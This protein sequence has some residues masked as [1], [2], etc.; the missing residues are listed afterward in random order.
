MEKKPALKRNIIMFIMVVAIIIS[1]IVIIYSNINSPGPDKGASVPAPSSDKEATVPTPS[2]QTPLLQ[3]QNGTQEPPDTDEPQPEPGEKVYI[4]VYTTYRELGRV[5]E[6]YALENWDFDFEVQTWD[7]AIR[8]GY[9][10]IIN[11]VDD[12]LKNNAEPMEVFCV[13]A[14]YAPKYIRGEYSQYVCPYEE[15]GIDVDALLEKMDIPRYIIDAGTNKEGKIVALPVL[16]NA[17]VFMYRRSVAREVFGTDDPDKISEIIGGGTQSWD[18]FLEASK[19]LKKHGY[20]IVSGPGDLFYQ[21][22]DKCSISDLFSEDFRIKPEWEKLMDIAKLLYDNGYIKNTELWSEQW[23]KDNVGKGDK[24]FGT[25][26]ITEFRWDDQGLKNVYGDVFGDW[27]ICLP[28]FQ[29]RSDSYSGIM[30]SRNAANKE[31][32]K[33]II[34]WLTL[35][36]SESGFQY[37]LANG[38]IFDGQKFPV[39]SRSVLKETENTVGFLGN[40]DVNPIVLNALNRLDERY[41]PD[42]SPEDEG[43]LSIYWEFMT[44]T[45]AYIRGEKDKETAISDFTE[46]IRRRW[47][48]TGLMW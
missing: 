47:K 17:N 45:N 22:D 23:Y 7:D 3:E 15:L 14:P 18:K 19:T 34:E 8:Y 9:N 2:S 46:G 12:N 21:I 24:V 10:D 13:P 20:Y 48:D 44:E 43:Y 40:Q 32:L 28:P 16:S 35:D 11:M 29:V 39:I 27:A 30:V 38:R 1:A 6:K 36:S 25:F 4:R 37:L 5:I 41:V 33:S 26:I 42:S 31:L